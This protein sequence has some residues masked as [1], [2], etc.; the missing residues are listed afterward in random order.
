VVAPQ[1]AKLRV[2]LLQCIH[3]GEAAA[4]ATTV[5]KTRNCG[6]LAC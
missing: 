1:R 5:A 6:S 4:E 2:R 3:R